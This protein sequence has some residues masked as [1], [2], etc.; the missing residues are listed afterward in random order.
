MAKMTEDELRAITDG[1]MRLSVGFSSG[2]LS[3]MRKEALQ[4]YYGEAFGNLAPPEVEG[5]SKVVSTDVRNTVESMLPQLMVKFVGSDECVTF[6]ANKPGD[7]E[8]AEQATDY[9]NH[10]FFTKN[11]GEK[12]AYTW[13]KDALISKNGIV[14]VWWDTAK[15][16]ARE[17]YEGLSDVELSQLMDDEEIEITEQKSYPDEEDQENREEALQQLSTQLQQAIQASQQNPQAAQAAQQIE[18]QIQAIQSAP[19]VMLYDVSCKRSKECGRIKVDNVPPE[20]FLI[21]HTAKNIQDA[22]FVGHRVQR[23][24]SQLKSMGYKNV[25][26]IGSD[27][28]AVSLNMER[29]ERLGYDDELAYLQT[30]TIANL[31]QSQR[32]IWVTECY[33]KVDFDGDGIAELRKV[34]RA[35]NQILENEVTDIVPFVSI[36]PIPLPHK[37]FGLSIWDLAKTTQEVNTAFLRGAIDNM[38]I[39]VNGRYY[40]V[41]GQCNL[42]DLLSSR[43][44]GV[45]RIKSPGAVGRLDQGS[46]DIA[47]TMSMMEY[48]KGFNEDSTGWT[49]YNQGSDGDSLNQTASGLNNIT[50]RADMRLDLIARNFA[51]GYRDLFRL[52]LKLVAQYQN[53]ED[54]VKLRGKWVPLNPRDWRQGFDATIN[55]GLGT[56]S[57]DQQVAHLMAM[58]G[59][60]EKAL[61]I[62]V[63]SPQSIYESAKEL[64][65]LLGFKTGDKFFTDPSQHPVQPQPHPE[66]IKA[67]A[68]MQVEQMK[69]QLSAQIEQEKMKAQNQVDLVRNQTEAQQHIAQMDYEAK[70]K[71]FESQIK[72]EQEKAKIAIEQLKIENDHWKAQ[73]DSNTKIYIEKMKLGEITGDDAMD[74]LAPQVTSPTQ[75]MREQIANTNMALNETLMAVKESIDHL[76]KPKTIIRD[77]NGRAQGVQ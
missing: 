28:Q 65:K 42:D 23:T 74:M 16:E 46:G 36:T 51:E 21:S 15:D 9:I 49:R 19:P 54:I 18:Q 63:A 48:M 14:K 50:S 3:N 39:G 40:A 8:K 32:M 47:G 75:E 70:L 62:G 6:E 34:V 29:A 66:Q 64:P 27:D 73:L 57:K 55:V 76:K 17:D 13:M 33:L 77:K 53:K 58:M 1:E 59:V 52:M 5:R 2:V 7:E 44:G 25:D 43:P 37:F 10:L 24:Q 26:E 20:E 31:D 12:I 41:D 35:G 56:G 69:A 67:Q 4:Y 61:A 72:H 11:P 45:V 60:Q 71:E 38:H 30:D 68:Q 22:S